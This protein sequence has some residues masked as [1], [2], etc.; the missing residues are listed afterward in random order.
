MTTRHHSSN[1]PRYHATDIARIRNLLAEGCSDEEIA[2]D[3]GLAAIEFEDAAY[4]PS[5]KADFGGPAR[6]HDDDY[7]QRNDAGEYC[8]M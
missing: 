8:W 1:H 2:L 7:Y 4:G 5:D 6:L 3:D